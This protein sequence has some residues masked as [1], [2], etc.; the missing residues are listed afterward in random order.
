MKTILRT[1]WAGWKK[2][3]HAFGV[4]QTKLILTI[5]YFIVIGIAALIARLMMKDLLD[6]RMKPRESHW[7]IRTQTEND[8]E[9]ARRQF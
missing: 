7:R 3:A 6:R 8:L 1:I 4:F 5:L 9:H 2:F